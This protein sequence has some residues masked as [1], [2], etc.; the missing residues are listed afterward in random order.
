MRSTKVLFLA[1][2]SGGASTVGGVGSAMGRML[3][4]APGR[5]PY[6]RPPVNMRNAGRLVG[7]GRLPPRLL[8]PLPPHQPPPLAPDFLPLPH[9][10]GRGQRGALRRA[11][12]PPANGGAR[13]IAR[14]ARP[15]LRRRG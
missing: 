10:R 13:V 2:S 8:P 14:R 6:H 3:R 4:Q 5:R 7:A 15:R 1:S 9:D 12:R 11:V